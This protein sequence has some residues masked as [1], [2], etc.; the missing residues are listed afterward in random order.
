MIEAH[1]CEQFAESRS[2]IA[3]R[4]ES[5]SL[6]LYDRHS[7]VLLA[8]ISAARHSYIAP[9]LWYGVILQLHQR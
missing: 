3:S 6:A 4:T 1:V 2:V 7:D 9:R 8:L 5:R